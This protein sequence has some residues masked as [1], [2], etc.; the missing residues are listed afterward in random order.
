MKTSNVLT[1]IL[2]GEDTMMCVGSFLYVEKSDN[3][4][5]VSDSLST[6]RIDLYIVIVVFLYVDHLF[7]VVEG[8]FFLEPH[9][10]HFLFKIS[11]IISKLKA[12][13]PNPSRIT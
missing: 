8:H 9:I 4:K 13:A 5:K 11:I 12:A 6:F 2:W 3:I 7:F 10:L 1:W